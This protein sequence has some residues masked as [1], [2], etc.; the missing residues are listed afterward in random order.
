MIKDAQRLK[1]LGIH[2]GISEVIVTTEVDKVPNAAPIGIVW[3]EDSII[4]RLFLG[5]HTYENILTTGTFVANVIHD[6]IIF[7]EAAMNDLSPDCF[8]HRDGVLTLKDAE[9]W[10]LFKCDPFR[11]DIMM[12]PIEFVRGQ[13]LWQDFRAVNRGT[14]L[15]VESAIAATRYQ[16]LAQDKYLD[17]IRAWNRIINR[18]GGPR[19]K[20]AMRRLDDYLWENR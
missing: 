3:D 12:L 19:D 1:E 11:T 5:T 7:V 16:A 2:P 9:S 6:P 17:D 14:N 20:E 8:Q 13:V 10:A 18:C 15:V 4:L